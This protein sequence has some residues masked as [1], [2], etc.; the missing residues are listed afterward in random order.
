MTN[1]ALDNQK[2]KQ[3][4]ALPYHWLD[5]KQVNT[6][7]VRPCALGLGIEKNRRNGY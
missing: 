1:H 4:K 7:T 2:S 5:K 3:S 6:E